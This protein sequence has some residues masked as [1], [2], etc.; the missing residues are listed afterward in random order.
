[1]RR[2]LSPCGAVHLITGGWRSSRV[3]VRAFASRATLWSA[4]KEQGE[5]ALTIYNFGFM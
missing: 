5:G 4:T 3:T 2:R 1:M